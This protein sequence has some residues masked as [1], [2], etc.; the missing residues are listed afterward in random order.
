MI[1]LKDPI[2][3]LIHLLNEK[4]D[5]A[6]FDDM[7]GTGYYPILARRL[8]CAGLANT[9]M[10]VTTHSSTQWINDLNQKPIDTIE[11]LS[12]TEI[13]RRSI[14][15]ADLVKSPSAYII[16]KYRAYGWSIPHQLT[17][18]PNFIANDCLPIDIR[19]RQPINELVFFGRLEKRKGL[20]LFCRALDR[21]KGH[22]VHTIVTFVGKATDEVHSDLLQ[23]ITKWPFE[24]RIITN[25]DQRQALD[26]LKMAGRLAIMP[27]IEDNSPSTILECLQEQIPFVATSGSG[28]EEL[29][30]IDTRQSNLF[31]PNVN[32]LIE[33][34][35]T[36][37]ADGAFTGTPATSYT[38]LQ[39]KYTHWLSSIFE[40]P[41]TSTIPVS[42]VVDK[43][44]TT[45]IVISNT[46]SW[47]RV[48]HSQ[49]NA[50]VNYAS[51][52]ISIIVLS[53]DPDTLRSS[54]K[55]KAFASSIEILSI[56]DFSQL[57]TRV[58]TGYAS[59]VFIC[60]ITL[61]LDKG[62]IFRA[63]RAL[64]TDQS[65]SAVT[66][67]FAS[68][69]SEPSAN[70]LPGYFAPHPSHLPARC[71][72]GKS[73][74]LLSLALETNSGFILLRGEACK[75]LT[76]LSPWDKDYARPKLMRDF[77]H[78]IVLALRN[79]GS[80]LKLFRTHYILE[81]P[82]RN[83]KFSGSN[84]SCEKTSLIMIN[85]RGDTSAYSGSYGNR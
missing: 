39:Q 16:S 22:L 27:S 12:L 36:I 72:V 5:L 23:R 25:F 74:V 57:M 52:D 78:E 66:G 51:N 34:L 28:G 31:E 38:S 50:I 83:S 54:L 19:R 21:M 71:L 64:N 44:H 26:Y 4:Y 10:C 29:L 53:S 14:A 60:S 77:I 13:E 35:E 67:I 59:S 48:Q 30:D 37:L 80:D 47:C 40:T 41:P 55:D 69:S 45:L 20:Y 18:L 61:K 73:T 85:S 32:S 65:L 63:N 33:K 3:L 9:L 43:P 70:T 84:A 11:K 82:S 49:L 79:S 81:L 62:W 75:D 8:G 58:E 2:Y 6:F 56:A 15:L 76:S 17:I 1:G 24:V 46:A 68:T 7:D 42:L